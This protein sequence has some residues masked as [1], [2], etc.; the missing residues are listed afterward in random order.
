MPLIECVP[1][2]SEGRDVSVIESIVAAI[3][4]A[5]GQV[6]DWSLDA[7][8]HRAVITFVAQRHDVVEAAFAAVRIARDRIDISQ[9]TG[10]HPRIGATDVVPFIPLDGATMDDCIIA[11]HAL[12]HRVGRELQIPAYLYERAARRDQYRNLADVRR[13]GGAAL[14]QAIGST[15]PP[16]DGPHRLHPTAGAV[17]IGAR[18]FLGAFNVFIG[19]ATHLTKARE[20]ARSIRASSGGL[21]GL[22]ALGLV[23]DGQAQ[24][25]LNVTDLDA[26]AL[27]EAFDAVQ[28]AARAHGIDVTHSEIIGL[29]PQRVI[30]RGFADRIRLRD[31][32]D[33]VSLQQRLA[34]TDRF[35]DLARTA[36][37]I[38]SL[39]QPPA[40]GTASALA[41]VLASSTVRLAANVHVARARDAAVAM[42]RVVDDARALE[43][44]LHHAAHD[45]AQAWSAVVVARRLP[46]DC[47]EARDAQLR[48]VDAALLGA[49]EV[50]LRIAHLAA[51]VVSLAAE[52]AVAGD[53]VTAPD[54]WAGATIAHAA[55]GAALGLMRSNL[56]MLTDAARATAHRE[57]AAAVIIRADRSLQQARV[58]VGDVAG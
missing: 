52:A 46:T 47:T 53:H 19:D 58:A 35:D 32:R 9:H 36:D 4:A 44:A 41:A 22:K 27:H 55:A 42:R 21:P 45:D 5:R 16:D 25:S 11:A 38:A 54:A 49:S 7:S 13:G 8:H 57:Q 10:V 30:E 37:A 23:V 29:V 56:G 24:V 50:P 3:T 1:N 12:A 51:D 28:H 20:I 33:T 26:V 39:D 15:R 6:L 31:A 14:E 48:A 40:S 2:F 34:D 18:E 17:A 43:Q